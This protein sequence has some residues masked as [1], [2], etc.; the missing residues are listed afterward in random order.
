MMG[1]TMP[2]PRLSPRAAPTAHRSL[3]DL[4][5]HLRP[6][7]AFVS[8]A[9]LLAGWRAAA[10]KAWPVTTTPTT[11]GAAAA[12]TTAAAAAHRRSERPPAA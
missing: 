3:T 1:E 2:I 5:W 10:G 9:S 6:P 8:A 11:W 12:E 7:G 4:L